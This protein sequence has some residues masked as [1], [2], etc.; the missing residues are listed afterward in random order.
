MDKEEKVKETGLLVD[1]FD[2]ESDYFGDMGASGGKN[3][4]F[5]D[6]KEQA[7]MRELE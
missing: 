1:N 7:K 2:D 4:I 6:S 5:N 3:D